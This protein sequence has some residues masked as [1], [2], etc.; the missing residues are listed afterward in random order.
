MS[1]TL[2]NDDTKKQLKSLQW[3]RDVVRNLNAK[4]CG[5]VGY[6]LR[7][8]GCSF[9]VDVCE[10][11]PSHEPKPVP[12]HCGLR[13]CP[14]CAARES[15]RLLMRYLPA[16]NKL[17]EPNAEHPDYRLRK[18]VFTTPFSLSDLSSSTFKSK[19]KLVK[20]FLNKFFYDYFL[21]LGAL[22]SSE[23]RRQRC[24]LASHGIGG[25]QA[26]EFGEKGKKL[27]WHVLIYSPYM[28][29]ADMVRVWEEVS[30]GECTNV[31]V[32]GMY[33]KDGEPLND[34]GDLLGA[35]KEVVKYS[36]KFTAIRP[37]DIPQ[38]HKVLK[39]NRRFRSFGVL[40]NAIPASEDEIDYCCEECHAAREMITVG[41]YLHRCEVRNIP[42]SD[43]VT[44]AVDDGILL[45]LSRD[46]EISSGKSETSPHKPR[47]SITARV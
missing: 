18:L 17:L 8:C 7:N 4:G 16:L 5:D 27:H 36:T 35:I 41:D 42:I 31:K 1:I 2:T 30:F 38:L 3:R 32:Y 46:I 39:G 20:D 11:D 37:R 15:H 29:H 26:A 45:Y 24:D 13:I 43:I 14:D 23:K 19:Q 28:E 21:P 44:N 6:K 47:D 10:N 40:Y 34:G 25:I 9:R 33:T 22:S 12:I